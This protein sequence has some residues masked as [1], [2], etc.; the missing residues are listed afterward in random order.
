MK[1]PLV[2]YPGGSSKSAAVLVKY[3]PPHRVYVE[4]FCGMASMFFAKDLAEVNVLNDLNPKVIELLDAV[5]T[6]QISECFPYGIPARKEDFEYYRD[7][8][9]ASACHDFALRATSWH[10]ALKGYYVNSDSLQGDYFIK[11]QLVKDLEPYIA[12]LR[13]ARLSIGDFRV[14]MQKYDSP[15]TLFFIDPPWMGTEYAKQW[16]E[17]NTPLLDEVAEECSNITGKAM[18]LYFGIR[19]FIEAFERIGYSIYKFQVQYHSG[20]NGA[21]TTYRVIATNWRIP[22]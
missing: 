17:I 4:P 5:R 14:V 19:R 20:L 8:R 15:E 2:K 10:G 12:K 22:T 11:K 6:G 16:Y 21:G 18:V 13:K 3:L 1:R 7:N 9:D